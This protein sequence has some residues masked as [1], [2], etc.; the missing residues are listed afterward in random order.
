VVKAEARNSIRVSLAGIMPELLGLNVAGKHRLALKCILL[1]EAEAS[2]EQ[3]SA[4]S[5]GAE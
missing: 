3:D 5:G 2:I 1:T 4:K